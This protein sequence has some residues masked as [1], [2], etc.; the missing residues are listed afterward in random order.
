MTDDVSNLQTIRNYSE[1]YGDF[2]KYVL[3][4]NNTEMINSEIIRRREILEESIVERRAVLQLETLLQRHSL[5]EEM[6]K[7]KDGAE[8]DES[9]IGESPSDIFFELQNAYTRGIDLVK[10][11]NA[12]PEKLF[13]PEIETLTSSLKTLEEKCKK[14]FSEFSQGLSIERDYKIPEPP[15]EESPGETHDDLPF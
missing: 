5:Q 12:T 13:T 9:Y 15:R 1:L 8:R 6:Q 3:E 7:L 11:F 2:V 10:R 4:I 14:V